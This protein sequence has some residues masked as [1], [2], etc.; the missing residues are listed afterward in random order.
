MRAASAAVIR[1][2]SLLLIN[3][4]RTSEVDCAGST[5]EFSIGRVCGAAGLDGGD[6]SGWQPAAI[7]TA[8]HRRW[9]F[10]MLGERLP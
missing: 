3:S 2:P 4:S 8:M 5:G 10:D 1:A 6:I 9:S 7:E